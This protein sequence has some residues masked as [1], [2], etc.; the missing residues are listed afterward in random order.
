MS[1]GTY[2]RQDEA[3]S[4]WERLVQESFKQ[5]HLSQYDLSDDDDEG[6]IIPT[7]Y[8]SAKT[9]PVSEYEESSHVP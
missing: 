4:D 2:T 5:R 1:Y 9:V 3:Q 7:T 6:L 8:E